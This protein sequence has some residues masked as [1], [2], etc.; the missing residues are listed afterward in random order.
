[1]NSQRR[2]GYA[3]LVFALGNAVDTAATGLDGESTLALGFD[4]LTVVLFAFLGV[5]FLTGYAGNDVET[6][7]E[8][9]RRYAPP[10]IAIFGFGVGALGLV[11]L[12]GA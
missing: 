9:F 5:A 3:F 11:S 4:V 6:N 1:M 8:W 12:L 2:F 7:P 10:V